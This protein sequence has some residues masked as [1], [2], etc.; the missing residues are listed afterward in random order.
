M[1]YEGAN[2]KSLYGVMMERSIRVS[3]SYEGAKYNS[4]NGVISEQNI[5]VCIEL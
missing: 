2:D 4:L 5:R 3:W 1:G